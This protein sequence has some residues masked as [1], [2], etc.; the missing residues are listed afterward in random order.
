MTDRIQG[1]IVVLDETLREDDAETTLIAI[2]QIKGVLQVSPQ[3]DENAAIFEKTR[4]KLKIIR[5]ILD[6]VKQLQESNL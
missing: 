3:K 2:K 1:F 5:K 4:V 6:F